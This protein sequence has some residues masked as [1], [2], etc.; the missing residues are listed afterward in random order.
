MQCC[1]Q[2]PPTFW[3]LRNL[4]I[5]SGIRVP[6]HGDNKKYYYLFQCVIIMH[7]NRRYINHI[8]VQIAADDDYVLLH[9]LCTCIMDSLHVLVDN[10]L[11]IDIGN[12]FRKT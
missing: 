1:M 8:G 3:E 2:A 10:N 11:I 4:I 7:G 5:H 12:R 6:L 9:C